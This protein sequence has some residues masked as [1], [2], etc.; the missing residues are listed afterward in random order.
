[1][2]GSDRVYKVHNHE[3]VKD[4]WRRLGDEEEACGVAV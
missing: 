4:W 3:R 2:S 1:M